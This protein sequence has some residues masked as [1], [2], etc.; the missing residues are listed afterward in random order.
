MLEAESI[1]GSKAY[2]ILK[3]KCPICNNG[4]VYKTNNP[5]DFKKFDKMY[6]NCS[7]CGHKYEIET[8]FF[9]G[10]MYVSY[11]ITVAIAV[12]IFVGTYVL[13]PQAEYYHYIINIILGM[14]LLM[15]ITFRH[16]RMVWMNLF[17]SYGKRKNYNK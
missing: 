1:K 7:Y 15:P 17:S 11:A 16:S 2:S 3:N 14:F 13:F 10:A 8:G 4:E 12:A 9:Y 6:D 5:Y